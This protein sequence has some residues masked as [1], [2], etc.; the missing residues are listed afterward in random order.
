MT[1]AER[2]ERLR[3]IRHW[4]MRLEANSATPDAF[5]RLEQEILTV[6][7]A[8]ATEAGLQVFQPTGQQWLAGLTRSAAR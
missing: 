7:D 2:V 8:I 1:P 5:T 3:A 6:E 4:L